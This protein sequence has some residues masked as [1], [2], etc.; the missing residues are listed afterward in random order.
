MKD[1]VVQD[2][3]PYGTLVRVCALVTAGVGFAALIGWVRGLPTLT[4]LGFGKIPMAPSTALLFVLYG[5]AAFLRVRSPSRSGVYRAGLAINIAGAMVALPLL[6]LSYRGIHPE[7]EH[8]WLPIAG[9]V[10]GAPIGHMS[11][12]AALCFLFA[13]VSFLA[14][15]PSSSSRPRRALA[16]WCSPKPA[17]RFPVR[18]FESR[19]TCARPPARPERSSG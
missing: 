15:L 2:R 3:I 14:S 17:H 1:N 19:A 16:A 4:S 5:I 18:P 6:F 8:L 10:G 11:P 13:T 9:M 12:V 7:A